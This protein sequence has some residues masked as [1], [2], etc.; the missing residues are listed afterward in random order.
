MICISTVIIATA[1]GSVGLFP[2][3]IFQEAKSTDSSSYCWN[4]GGYIDEKKGAC[5][6]PEQCPPGTERDFYYTHEIKC[7]P[8]TK[9][10]GD[11]KQLMT[12]MHESSLPV[13]S[14]QNFNI[15]GN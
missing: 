11:S 13:N 15:S 14:S 2:S 3:S 8:I 4:L 10:S 1:I 6:I 9:S 7:D 5:V 12:E